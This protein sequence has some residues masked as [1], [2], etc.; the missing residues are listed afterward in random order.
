MSE[1]EALQLF[2]EAL[3]NAVQVL[4]QSLA[5]IE[6]PKT[7]SQ[8]RV[9]EKETFSVLP[10]TPEKGATLGDYEV[11]YKNQSASDSWQHAFNILK[12]NNSLINSR[13]HEPG[14][15]FGYWIFQEKPDRIFRKK[16]T[17]AGKTA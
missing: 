14:Y 2:A 8:A 16:L 3:E 6:K 9:P 4:R 7:E 13:L 15:Q 11:S 12:A 1:A 17:E 10:W 5:R